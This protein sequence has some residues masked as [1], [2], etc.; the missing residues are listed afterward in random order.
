MC[1]HFLQHLEEV[2]ELAMDVADQELRGS[3]LDYVG[4]LDEDLDGSVCQLVDFLLGE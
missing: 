3:D 4:L 1:T 2:V